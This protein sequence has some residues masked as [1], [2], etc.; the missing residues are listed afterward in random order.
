MVAERCGVDDDI[1][2]GIVR[3]PFIDEAVGLVAAVHQLRLP[4]DLA[5][6]TAAHAVVPSH[7]EVGADDRGRC[8]APGSI[9]SE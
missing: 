3:I 5:S 8:V 6:L 2:G 4:Q 1:V 9:G 7:D